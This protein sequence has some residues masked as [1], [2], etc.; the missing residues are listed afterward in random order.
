[1]AQHR[2]VGLRAIDIVRHSR[3]TGGCYNALTHGDDIIFNLSVLGH[4]RFNL[5]DDQSL[6][7]MI[8]LISHEMAHI[9]TGMDESGHYDPKFRDHMQD[10]IGIFTVLAMQDPSFFRPDLDQDILEE[11]IVSGVD[12]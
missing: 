8:S 9:A 7:K 11:F 4:S 1:M 3:A 2:N 10:S 12:I 6:M 5:E